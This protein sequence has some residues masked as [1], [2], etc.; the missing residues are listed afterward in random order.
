[1]TSP[2]GNN[3]TAHSF[4]RLSGGCVTFTFWRLGLGQSS[5]RHIT[6]VPWQPTFDVFSVPAT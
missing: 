5:F 1:M 6:R 3:L 4:R 2:L